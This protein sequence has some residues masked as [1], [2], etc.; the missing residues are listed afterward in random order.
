MT[1]IEYLHGAIKNLYSILEGN[2]AALKS[3]GDVHRPYPSLYRLELYVTDELYKDFIN[4]FQQL[5]GVLR[6]SIELSRIDI[7]E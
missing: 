1:C 6:W 4:R 3:F 7:M 2:K 5:I